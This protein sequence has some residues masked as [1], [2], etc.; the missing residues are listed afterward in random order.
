MKAVYLERFGGPEV[1]QYGDLADPVD[2][3]RH[4]V[5]PLLKPAWYP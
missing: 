4:R 3:E 2:G 1:L 5:S